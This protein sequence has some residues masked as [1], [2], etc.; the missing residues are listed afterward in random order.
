M[1]T[2]DQARLE[3]RKTPQ[4]Q[5][6]EEMK[7]KQDKSDAKVI[8]EGSAIVAFISHPGWIILKREIE[9]VT[10]GLLE[11]L[12]MCHGTIRE[13]EGL[14]SEIKMLREF[15]KRPNE[16]IERLKKLHARKLK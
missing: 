7:D 6:N 16:Y 1:N 15:I 5:Y 3:Q 9:G 11:K 10:N 14:Q 8:A 4:Q 2:E 13:R 12:V